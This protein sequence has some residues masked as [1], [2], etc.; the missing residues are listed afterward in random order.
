MLIEARTDTCTTTSAVN[1]ASTGAGM[2]VT[3]RAIDQARPAANPDLATTPSSVD[4]GAVH[5][6]ARARRCHHAWARPFSRRGAGAFHA[7]CWMTSTSEPLRSI[8]KAISRMSNATAGTGSTTTRAPIWRNA[9]I[10]PRTAGT[11]NAWW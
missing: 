9:S 2:S 10:A 7:A 4:V 11:S 8:T 5:D 3:S 6:T 1:G